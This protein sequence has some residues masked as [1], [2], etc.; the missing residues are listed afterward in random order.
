MVRRLSRHTGVVAIDLPGLVDVA[1]TPAPGD[2]RSLA[3][4]VR[5]VIREH[6]L[7]NVT[8]VGHDVGGQIVY[9]YL[10]AFP[11]ELQRA[12]LMNV[13]IPD[14]EP[15]SEVIHNPHLWHFAF[16]AVPA[17]PETLVAGQLAA[18]FEFFFNALASPRGVPLADRLRYVAAYANR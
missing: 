5:T 14:V 10:R 17:L 18:Y 1:E 15:W 11:N 4:Q 7:R 16:Q 12:V 6:G 13:V 8:L 9:G 3:R 2:M